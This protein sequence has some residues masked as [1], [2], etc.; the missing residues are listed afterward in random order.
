MNRYYLNKEDDRLQNEIQGRKLVK[1]NKVLW[2][3][4]LSSMYSVGSV[5]FATTNCINILQEDKSFVQVSILEYFLNR[6]IEI[7]EKIQ[8]NQIE[9]DNLDLSWISGFKN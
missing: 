2:V 5:K 4:S 1:D 9:F 7:Y 3:I 6:L 8:L